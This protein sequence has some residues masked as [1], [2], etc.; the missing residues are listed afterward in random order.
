[1]AWDAIEVDTLSMTEAEQQGVIE[2][3][4]RWN[5]TAGQ[6]KQDVSVLEPFEAYWVMNAADPPREIVLHVPPVQ[7]VVETAPASARRAN[8][9]EETGAW[10]IA[11]GVIC[12][13]AGTGHNV[14]GTRPGALDT[15]DPYDRSEPP[16][17]PGKSLSLYFPHVDWKKHPGRYAVDI[18]GT[19]EEPGTATPRKPPGTESSWGRVWSFDIAKNFSDDTA[20]DEIALG[21]SGIDALPGDLEI[22]LVDR[23]LELVVDLR[24]NCRYLFYQGQR[25]YVKQE[26]ARFDLL[27]GSGIFVDTYGDGLPALPTE[28]VLHQNHPNP[29]NPSTIIRYEVATAGRVRIKV[30]DVSGA[31]VK[32][33]EDTNLPPGRYEIG[34]NGE[35][36]RGEKVASGVYFYHLQTGGFVQTKKMVLIK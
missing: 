2:P 31:L 26:E 35:N 18:R 14:I 29:F 21:F 11:V 6:Y 7:A 4:W 30:Y 12:N 24:E 32:V 19:E 28:T 36:K 23:T 3:L 9:T 10:E 22:V 8:G 25:S 34:W 13:D 33:L 15:Y 1:V 17:S 27:V 20:G 5:P 16:M